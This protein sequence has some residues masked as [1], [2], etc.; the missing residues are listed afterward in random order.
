MFQIKRTRFGAEWKFNQILGWVKFTVEIDR[1]DGRYHRNGSVFFSKLAFIKKKKQFWRSYI[2]STNSQI[3]QLF[4]KTLFEILGKKSR[5]RLEDNGSVLTLINV[6]EADS[7]E[8]TCVANNGVPA[9]KPVQISKT[10][11]LLV[12]RKCFF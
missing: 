11:Y 10:F 2:C 5:T 6:T 9:K 4:I 1:K 3:V 12:R 8:F 7:G